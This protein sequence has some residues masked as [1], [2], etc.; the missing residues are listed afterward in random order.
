MALTVGMSH[1]SRTDTDLLPQVFT[2]TLY[3]LPQPIGLVHL[4]AARL[5]PLAGDLSIRLD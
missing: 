2:V 1:F 3:P 4:P 5:Q